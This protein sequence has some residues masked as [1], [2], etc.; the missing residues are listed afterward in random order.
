MKMLQALQQISAI[1]AFQWGM[2]TSV[3]ASQLGVSTLVLSRLTSAGLLERVGRGVYRLAGAPAD[4][5]E[6]LKAAWLSTDPGRTASARLEDSTA[7]V[8]VAGASAAN[9]H[10][11][12]DLW[13][14]RHDFVSPSR[15]QSQRKGLRF[16]VRTLV[17]QDV[18]VIGGLPV[19]S[20]ERALADLL[21]D[22]GD[23]SLVAIALRDAERTGDLD[24]KHLRELLAP[25]AA[26]T[27]FKAGGGT[28]LLD[29]LCIVAGI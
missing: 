17:P 1:T 8:V 19:M 7:G 9:L 4:Q 14:D 18:T 23:V 3:Q 15:R 24:W 13:A 29:H 12:G 5:H 2:I 28:A 21:D 10:G 16:R 27:G 22:L 11:I 6:A 20:V 26:R 25:Y